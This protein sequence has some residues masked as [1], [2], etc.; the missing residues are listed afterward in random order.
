[1]ARMRYVGRHR[2]GH[3]GLVH[4]REMMTRAGQ[5][6][7]RRWFGRR[8]ARSRHGATVI[9]LPAAGGA[10]YASATRAA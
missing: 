8:V 2:R 7:P 5:R 3:P 9:P 1:M 4:W 10:H 6:K